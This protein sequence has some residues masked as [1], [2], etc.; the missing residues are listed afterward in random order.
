MNCRGNA[1]V[2]VLIAVA[3]FAGLTVTLSNMGGDE[4]QSRIDESY[5]QS[6]ITSVFAYAGSTQNAIE[7]MELQGVEIDDINFMLPSETNFNTAPV[8]RKLFHPEGGGLNY[9]PLPTEIAAPGVTFP[10]GGYYVD[11][12]SNVEWTPTSTNPSGYDVIF[13]AYGITQQ[14]CEAINKK[15][16]GSS[17]VP[18]VSPAAWPRSLFVETRHHGGGNANFMAAANCPA[19]NGKPALCVADD[20]V[21]LYAF[22]NILYAR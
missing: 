19:C 2:Y 16:T 15:I 12:F 21:T 20:T 4:S 13:V 17:T 11:K 9:I 3:L 10:D 18:V 14:A 22:Y 1:F 6:A 8:H 5:V 7:Q